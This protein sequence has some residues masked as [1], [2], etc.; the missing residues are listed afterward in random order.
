MVGGDS[1]GELVLIEPG[2]P[3]GFERLRAARSALISWG[4]QVTAP[5][6]HDDPCP[7]AGSDWCHFAVRLERSNLHREL[8][9]ARLGYEDEKY[10][11]LAVSATRPS[12]RLWPVW[13]A[14]R[15]CTRVTCG[16]GCARRVVSAS[17]SSA[18]AKARST[19]APVPPAGVTVS[20]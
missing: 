11:Y 10:S 15:A 5:C 1:S 16:S 18:G 8:K 4:A 2:T 12:V 7:M 14:R 9:G 17:V 3:A 20:S 13:C 6:P 19:G